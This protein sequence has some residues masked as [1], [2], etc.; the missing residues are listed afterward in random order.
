MSEDFS[1]QHKLHGTVVAAENVCM[2]GGTFDL[3]HET[4]GHDKVVDAPAD[5]LLTG[6]ETVGPP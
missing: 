6:M 2:D 5:I 1:F 4:L 3:R